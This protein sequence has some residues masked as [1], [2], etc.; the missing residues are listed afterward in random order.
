MTNGTKG[1]ADATVRLELPAG[2]SATPAERA[3][4]VRARR[5]VA[6]RAL[7]GDRAGA[8]EGRRL[9]APRRRDVDGDRRGALRGRLSGDRVSAHPAPSDHQAGRD[10]AQDRRR[11]DRAEP[12]PSATSTASAIRCR[13]RSS[14]WARSSTFI[15]QD[16]L[17]WGDLSK[18]DVIV[19][20]VRAYERRADLRAY[21]RRLL[22]YAEQG[23]TVIV[24]Y[25]KFEF[26]QAQYGP[27]PASVSGNRV[28]DET[29]PV[30]MLV[31][32]RP[33]VQLSE[34]DRSGDVGQLGAGAR[35]VLPRREGSEVRG[36]GVDDRLVPGQSRAKSSDRSWKRESARAAG[37]ISVSDSGVNCRPAPTARIS[38]W[39][40]CSVCRR[41]RSVRST[42]ER[43]AGRCRPFGTA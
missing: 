1:A 39:R 10:D 5:R 26:N 13:R 22:D 33:G 35:P 16:E 25:N 8:G 43:I 31:P 40:T 41:R 9:H 23:G 28:S 38:C 7:S 32:E 34:Q 14:S 6:V 17:A 27:Y 18:Y 30:K 24:Q 11:E 4:R 36:S 29:V 37:S 20:G 42:I 15:D 19:T 21:N 12:R 2:W 3:D